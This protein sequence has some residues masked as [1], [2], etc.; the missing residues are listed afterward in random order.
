[1]KKMNLRKWAYPGAALSA[2]LVSASASAQE[3]GAIDT[4]AAES[5]FSS[6]QEKIM[7]IGGIALLMTVGIAVWKY[8]QAAAA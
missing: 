4:S 6:G 1:M 8:I 5:L 7:A 3:A 2:A